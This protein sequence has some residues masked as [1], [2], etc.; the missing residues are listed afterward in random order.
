[1]NYESIEENYATECYN[2]YY[3]DLD[4]LH[5]VDGSIKTWKDCAERTLEFDVGP[6]EEE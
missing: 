1:M 5:N 3:I 6:K 4:D 2:I